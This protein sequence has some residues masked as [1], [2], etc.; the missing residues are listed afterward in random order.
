MY[1]YVCLHVCSFIFP[2]NSRLR[3]KTESMDQSHKSQL[4]EAQGKLREAEKKLKEQLG[5]LETS[6]AYKIEQVEQE[7]D[8]K[9]AILNDEIAK[10]RK[11]KIVLFCSGF[12]LFLFC[13]NQNLT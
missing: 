2:Q 8:R 13:F 10:E 1:V 11:V 6:S 5:N 7:A 9:M 3:R 4:S 12:T